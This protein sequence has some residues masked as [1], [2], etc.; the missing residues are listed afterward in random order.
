MSADLVKPGVLIMIVCVVAGERLCS[1]V[2]VSSLRDR[3]AVLV[4]DLYAVLC[5]SYLLGALEVE[6]DGLAL[7]DLEDEA[8]SAA[9]CCGKLSEIRIC[10]NKYG[11]L[12]GGKSGVNGKGLVAVRQLNTDVLSVRSKL[13]GNS[14]HIVDDRLND[15]SGNVS[16]VHLNECNLRI[17]VLIEA[18]RLVS[19]ECSSL[20]A[21][22]AGDIDRAIGIALEVIGVAHLAEVREFAEVSDIEVSAVVAC[23]VGRGISVVLELVNDQVG[24]GVVDLLV[25]VSDKAIEDALIEDCL[26]AVLL[27]ELSKASGHIE[28]N[29]VG[30][31][32]LFFIKTSSGKVEAVYKSS[33]TINDALFSISVCE[34]SKGSVIGKSL[35]EI[36]LNRLLTAIE[37]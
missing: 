13:R 1:S 34:V 30:A 27:I 32:C 6:H 19:I 25:S 11:C 12:I 37:P 33:T 31:F 7:L 4:I 26:V 9:A 20:L 15:I 14:V 21:D 10:I 5:K 8:F 3:I 2:A 23:K 28:V 16:A 24:L 22:T 18:L 35:N 17:G 36:K 29:I